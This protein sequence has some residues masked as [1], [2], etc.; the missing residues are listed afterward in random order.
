MIEVLKNYSK[1][2]F[3]TVEISPRPIAVVATPIA[4]IPPPPVVISEI[5]VN[6]SL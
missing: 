2:L 5:T 3:R 6:T 4:A 1:D